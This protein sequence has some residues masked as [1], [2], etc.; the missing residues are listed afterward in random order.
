[1]VFFFL[2]SVKAGGAEKSAGGWRAGKS[3]AFLFERRR[4]ELGVEANHGDFGSPAPREEEEW[5]APIAQSE[6]GRAL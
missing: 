3:E 6:A 5:A 4:K 2:L 1:M